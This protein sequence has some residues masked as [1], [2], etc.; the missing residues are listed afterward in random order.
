MRTDGTSRRQLTNDPYQDRVPRWSPDGKKIG[1]YSNRSG[2]YE[3]WT[4]NPDG[5]GLQQLTETPA[6]AVNLSVW[7]PDGLRMA[8]FNRSQGRAYIFD[9]NKSWQEQA[10]EPLPP[11]GEGDEAFEVFSWSPDG[12]WLAAQ[13]LKGDGTTSIAI[14]NLESKHY[15]KLTDFGGYPVWLTDSRRLLFRDAGKLFLLDSESEKVQEILSLSPDV[16]GKFS[17]SSDDRWIYLEH[18]STEADIWMLTLNEEQK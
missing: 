3:I 8:C 13:V 9:V 11:F 1:F 5:S 6:E 18:S 14:Y 16:I 4:I 15:R 12:K 7:S 2:T 17:I 10:P